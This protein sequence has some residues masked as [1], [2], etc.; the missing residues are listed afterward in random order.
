MPSCN[1]KIC[2]PLI[3]STSPEILTIHFSN[4]P[5]PPP[6]STTSASEVLLI[7]PGAV[8]FQINK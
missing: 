7:D 5:K 6:T 3:C 8:L 2:T 1:L 4:I